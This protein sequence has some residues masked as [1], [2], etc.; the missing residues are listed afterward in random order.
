M[1]KSVLLLILILAIVWTIE[2]VK[3]WR[4]K[5]KYLKAGKKWE[6][7]IEELSDRK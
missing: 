4:T 5:Q 2:N 7:I 1:N 3:R 6:N